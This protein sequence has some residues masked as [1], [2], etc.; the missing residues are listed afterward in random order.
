MPE[1][2]GYARSRNINGPWKFKGIINDVPHNCVTNR[3]RI[4]DFKDHSWF[5]YHNGAL[6]G[7]SSHRRS[8]CLD[9]LHYNT[10]GTIRKMLMTSK[11][12]RG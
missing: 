1:K 11:G 6:P 9:A 7:G 10:D 3:P 4:I 8:V 5:I 2:V 12:I